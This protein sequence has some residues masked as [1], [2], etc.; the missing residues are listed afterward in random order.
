[1][2]HSARPGI[3]SVRATDPTAITRTSY[4]SSYGSPSSG[5]TVATLRACSTPVTQPVTTSASVSVWRSGTTVWRGWIE[6]ALASG[7]NGW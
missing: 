6:P 5:C 1:M 7:R 2:A 3:G 4:G